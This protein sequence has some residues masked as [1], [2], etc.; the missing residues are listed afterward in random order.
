MTW[1]CVMKRYLEL[2][3]GRLGI[4][5]AVLAGLAVLV[6][7]HI[8]GSAAPCCFAN[9]HY[10]GTCKVIPGE[11]ET[12]Q[13]I[14]DYLNNPMSTG[15]SYCGGTSVRGGWVLA[16]CKKGKPSIQQCAAG[17]MPEVRNPSPASE[18]EANK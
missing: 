13:S 12:C 1:G 14:L 2:G 6:P 18:D 8:A 11:G 7:A 16:D 4:A 9:D 15:K 10:E 17:S 3:W 5:A